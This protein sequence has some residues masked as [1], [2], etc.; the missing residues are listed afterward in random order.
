MARPSKLTEKQWA[1]IERRALAGESV[2]ALA[3]EFGISPVTIR[4]HGVSAHVAEIKNVAQQI[5]N[6]ENT[7]SSMSVSAQ[8]SARSLALELRE[9]STNLAGA[10][11]HGSKTA[12]RLSEIAALQVD[13]INSD[14]PMES[15]EH[16][17]AISALTR[18]SNDSA[19][20]SVGLLSA[21][22]ESMGPQPGQAKFDL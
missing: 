10:A 7:L 14:D 15:Q 17:Q 6:V 12:Y 19:S 11:R 5:V 22:T 2:R 13:K 16:L 8:V 3:R 1:E 20:Q 18:M 21:N 4:D 9:I